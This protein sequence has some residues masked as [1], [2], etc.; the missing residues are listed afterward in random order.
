[1]A[2]SSLVAPA[3]DAGA[4]QVQRDRP[5]ALVVVGLA[6]LAVLEDGDGAM[7][8]VVVELLQGAGDDALGLAPRPA[9]LQHRLEHAGQE[10]RL[11]QVGSL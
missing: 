8:D 5:D 7:A 10:E 4:A 3:G 9:L 2:I 11:P 6:A 1:M